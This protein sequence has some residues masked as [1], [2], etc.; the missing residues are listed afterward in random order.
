MQNTFILSGLSVI[1]IVAG[2]ALLF[3]L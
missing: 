1:L 2:A 3:A